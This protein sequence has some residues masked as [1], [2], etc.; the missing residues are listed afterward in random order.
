MAEE[1]PC[2]SVILLAQAV[3]KVA[4][5]FVV[6]LHELQDV[7]QQMPYQ[8]QRPTWRCQKLVTDDIDRGVWTAVRGYLE[9]DRVLRQVDE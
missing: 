4:K 9:I 2:H 1:I 7:S 3:A 8:L 6:Q 5:Y